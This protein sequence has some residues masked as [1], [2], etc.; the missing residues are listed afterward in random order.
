MR[1]ELAR[2]QTRILRLR[3]L[4]IGTVVMRGTCRVRFHFSSACPPRDWRLFALS[5]LG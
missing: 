4:K 5:S 2:A 1:T 3:L